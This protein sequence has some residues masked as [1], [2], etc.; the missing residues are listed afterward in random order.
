MVSHARIEAYEKQ[1][2]TGI[3][4]VIEGVVATG[5]GVFERE[6]DTV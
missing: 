6:R 4:E 1:K 5:Y 2:P 3:T